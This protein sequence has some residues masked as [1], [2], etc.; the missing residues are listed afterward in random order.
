MTTQTA[1][2]LVTIDLSFHRAA[3]GVIRSILARHGVSVV[4]SVAPHEQAFEQLRDGTA[5]ML[6]SAWLPYSHDVYFAPIAEQFEKVTVLYRPYAYWGVPG[7]VPENL[8]ASIDDLRKP[9]VVERMEKRIQ[10]I[11]PGAGISRFSRT[12]LV[13][14]RLAELGYRFE[15]G[16]LDDC[17][18]AYEKAVAQRKWAVV[19]LWKPQYLHEKH[20]IRQLKDPLGVMGG[21]DEA[22]LVATHSLMQQLP[23]EAV[24]ELRDTTLGNDRVSHLDYL[25]SHRHA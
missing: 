21:A 22:T 2:R 11:G 10:G 23:A 4:E 18:G 17:V 16:S 15:N 14:Y 6:C 24:L 20:D 25:I 1:V 12:A 7:Y 8:V 9:E 19:P 13:D 3:S 5:D